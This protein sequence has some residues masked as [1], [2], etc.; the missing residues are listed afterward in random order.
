MPV[1]VNLGCVYPKDIL[2]G[3][4]NYLT[5]YVKLIYVYIRIYEY[6]NV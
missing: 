1:V 2:G 5:G 3:K 6:I 4:R